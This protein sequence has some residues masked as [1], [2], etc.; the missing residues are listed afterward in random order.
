MNALSLG[1]IAEAAQAVPNQAAVDIGLDVAIVGATVDSRMVQP[2]DLFVAVAGERVDG[3]DFARAAVDSGA[4][5]VLASR[6]IEDVPCLVTDDPILSLGRLAHWYRR[7]EL[8]ATVI[9]VTGSSGKTTTKDLI[10]DVLPGVVVAAQG[11]FNTEVGVPLTILQADS[12][13]DFLILEMGMRGLGHIQY[14]A[15]MAE[16]DVGVVLNVGLA[17]VGMMDRP[18]SIAEAKSE[19]VQALSQ[20]AVAVLNVDDHAVRRMPDVVDARIVW[21]GEGGSADVRAEDV[22]IDERGRPSFELCVDGEQSVPVSL[23]FHGE[24]FV[25]A[26]LAAAA[27]GSACAMTAPDIGLALE[28]AR[29]RSRWRMDVGTSPSGVTVINDAYNA[30]PD[31]MRAALKTLRAM[32]GSGRTWAVLGE[33]LE[34][35]EMSLDEH[36]SIGRL[37]V[38]LDIS[39]LVCVGPGTKVMHLAASNEGSWADESV[40]V[41]DAEA[42]IELLDRELIAGDTVLVKASRAVGIE[43]IADHL[44]SSHV[45]A[46][47]QAE[48]GDGQ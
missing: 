8:T 18:E 11:S 48:V 24:H 12:S 46:D 44:M 6:D 37:A 10:A 28:N 19:L 27:V 22:R 29:P 30:N 38:R 45:S 41:A 23:Q 39:R 42:A 4:V 17:H 40:W 25:H 47:G 14:L 34:L 5:A 35:G 32:G 16:P 1:Q 7:N 43:V 21:F 9:G 26:A 13:T 3:H 36:D 33:M 31:S 15:E 20:D 2:G